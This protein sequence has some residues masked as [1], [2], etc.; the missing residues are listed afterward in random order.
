MPASFDEYAKHFREAQ[1]A[2][3]RL[4]R[5]LDQL[6]TMV[7]EAQGNPAVLAGPF[8][9][10]PTQQELHQMFADAQNKTG[11]LAAEYSQLPPDTKT[12]APKPNTAALRPGGRR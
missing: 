11:P 3:T 2:W 8:M 4:H 10:W 12:Y 7:G 5:A 9:A 1:D 6:F